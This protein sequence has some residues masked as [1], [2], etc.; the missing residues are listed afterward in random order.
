MKESIKKEICEFYWGLLTFFTL[1]LP[2][3][4]LLGIV[5]E[6]VTPAMRIISFILFIASPIAI[7]W[8]SDKWVHAQEYEKNLLGE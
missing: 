6:G 2:F 4:G 3:T 5:A 1:C 8:S 7:A